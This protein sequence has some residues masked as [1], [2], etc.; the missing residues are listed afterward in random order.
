MAVYL[1]AV[2]TAVPPHAYPQT[3]LRDLMKAQPFQERLTR[4]LIGR[5]YNASGIETRHSVLGELH[6]E[7][8]D[9]AFF[10][11]PLA[12]GELPRL[13]NATTRER[14]DRYT[15]EA[16]KLFC[17]AGRAALQ[18]TPFSP[19]DVTHVVTVS[20]TGF[21]APGPDYFLVRDLGLRHSVQRSHL[22]FMGCYAAFPAL[23]AAQ[24][25]CA[26]DEHAVVLVV[27]VELC[28][29]HFQVK[30]DPDSLIAG[31]VFADG[32]AAALVSARPPRGGQAALVLDHFETTLIP[33]GEGDMAWNVGNH[34]FEM[35]LSSY[36]P[37][38]IEENV[39]AALEPLLAKSGT[40]REA[41]TH[42]AVHPGGRSILDKVQRTLG[43][44]DGQ[45]EPSREVLRSYGNMSSATVL[46]VLRRLLHAPS[47]NSDER[48]AA[49]AFGPGLTVETALLT[50]PGSAPS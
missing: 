17:E 44:S 28:S 14:N 50:K 22:G 5:M 29:L 35:V 47:A 1:H 20:C 37:S 2:E 6:G 46:F 41:L 34:G 33:D 40:P 13:R 12:E 9:G 31:S 11:R 26:Q 15:T 18:A 38:I 21:F 30:E 27:C 10:E 48:V 49:L 36:V 32:A 23:R 8:G 19:K 24:A 39:E 45:M 7:E 43:L 16:R 4:P 42:W 3:L 25:F